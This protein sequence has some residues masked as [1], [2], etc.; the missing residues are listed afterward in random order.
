LG[1]GYRFQH[2]KRQY[3]KEYAELKAERDGE[4]YEQSKMFV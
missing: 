2:L 4:Y 1:S 3:P